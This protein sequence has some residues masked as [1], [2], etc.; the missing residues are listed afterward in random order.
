MSQYFKMTDLITK[1]KN[2][3]KHSAEEI[4][5]IVSGA[6]NVAIPDYQLSAWLMA[7]CLKGMDFEESSILTEA[8]A[9]S[10]D[11]LDLSC[12]GEN[13]TDKHSTGGVGDKATLVLI[14]LLAAAGLKTAK[15]SGRGLGHTG[16]TIDKLE[17]IPGFQT[18]LDLD[19]FLNQVKSIGAA[20]SSQTLNL[21]PADARIYALRDVTATIDSI[22]LIASSVM[23]KKIAAGANIIVLDVKCGSGAFMKTVEEASRLAETMVQIGNKLNKKTAAVVTDMEQPLGCAVG[24]SL[25]VKEAIDTLKNNGPEDLKKLCLYLGAISMVKAGKAA[26]IKDAEIILE[27]HLKDGSAFEKFKEIASWQGADIDYIDNPEKLPFADHIIEVKSQNSG[28]V[29]K[30]DALSVAKACKVLGA[31]RDKKDDKIDYS[32]GILLNKKIGDRVEKDEVLARI[33]ANDSE[34]GNISRDL[35][36][37]AFETSENPVI[38][39]D[40]II[41]TIE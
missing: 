35:M 4:N 31:G 8:M 9:N 7:V 34:K 24:N 10:G 11:I 29:E 16:G 18:Y 32:V 5:Y 21:A 30:L 25:E 15:L 39:P 1:K 22:P 19:R 17:S 6:A 12:L 37:C 27:N 14:P 23:S 26:D 2:G 40:L 20:I 28:F 41:K 3:E 33:Y 38:K 36:L 13:I